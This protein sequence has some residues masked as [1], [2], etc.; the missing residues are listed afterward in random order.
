MCILVEAKKLQTHYFL[1]LK[2]SVAG[3]VGSFPQ[4]G[5]EYIPPFIIL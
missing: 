4:V 2:N 5:G 1:E 3:E